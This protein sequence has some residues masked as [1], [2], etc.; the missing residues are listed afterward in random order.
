MSEFKDSMLQR[1]ME[2]VKFDTQSDDDAAS[3]PTTE[4]QFVF[5]RYL[6]QKLRDMGLTE[7]VLDDKGYLYATLPANCSRE[8]PTIG[9]IAHLDTSPDMS[10]KDVKPRVVEAYD[11]ADIVLDGEAG[12]VL[13]TMDFPEVKDYVGHDLVVTD[14]HTLL[15]ADDKAGI[16][17]IVS[18]IDYLQQHP[19]IEHGKVRIAFNP[20]EEVGRGAHKF[21]VPLFGCDWAY[22]VD[23]SCEGEIEFEN[24]NAGSATFKIQGR[25][26]HPGYAKGKMLNALRVANAIV[27]AIPA[28]E[29]PECTEGYEGFYHLMG[30]NGGVDSASVSYI[31]RDHSKDI[32][33]R[34]MKFMGE[35]AQLI[36]N[37]YGEGTVAL[38]LKVQYRNMRE[39]VEPKMFIIELAKSAM[40][41][42]GVEP[43]VKPIRGGTDGAQLSFM[44][45]PCPNLFAGGINFHSRY[46]F[47][48]LQVMEK[49][50]MTIVK[51]IEGVA[52]G[53]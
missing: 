53:C 44:G 22:T 7:I 26:V 40:Q 9:F 6:E 52:K 11:G 34:R 31:I 8:L 12:I 29:S 4:G 19:E 37:R 10:G 48:S 41:Q 24:F 27:E 35:V 49:A 51:I 1:F 3:V 32:F 13:S 25:N 5:A 50:V 47:V 42:A 45:L 18:A 21:D 46:E 33:E 20:D 14:G 36:N 17:E 39:M 43:R 30:I 38:D 23:G 28:E 2:Y 16:A 15:G